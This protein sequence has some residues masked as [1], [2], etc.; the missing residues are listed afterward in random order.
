MV[1]VAV[2]VIVEVLFV[3]GVVVVV[4]GEGGRLVRFLN[5]LLKNDTLSGIGRCSH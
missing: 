2:V 1:V 3:G 5:A 4:V